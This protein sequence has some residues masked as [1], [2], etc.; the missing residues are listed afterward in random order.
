M[1]EEKDEDGGEG[2]EEED[3]EVEGSK[4]AQSQ[5]ERDEAALIGPRV[6]DLQDVEPYPVDIEF[7]SIPRMAV[8]RPSPLTCVNQDIVS[9]PC[10]SRRGPA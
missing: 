7:G 10:F 9:P 8:L 5:D 4:R 2:R 6:G 3:D 1:K